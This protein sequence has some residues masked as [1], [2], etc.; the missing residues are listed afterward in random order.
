MPVPHHR[1]GQ[2]TIAKVRDSDELRQMLVDP[3]LESETI[4][5]K[6]NWVTNEP[7]D[8]TESGTLRTLIEA[9]DSRIVITESHN[10]A[11]SMNLLENGMNFT[12]GSREV[13]WRWLLKGDGWNWLIEMSE[14][15][16]PASNSVPRTL[17]RLTYRVAMSAEMGVD[18]PSA[19][20]HFG[21]R[22]K[23]QFAHLG[24]VK[25]TVR[26][27]G[28][29]QEIFHDDPA[30]EVDM[31]EAMRAY[32]EVGFE[33][34]MRPDHAP[35]MIGDQ[36]FEGH[37]G[38]YTLGKMLALGYMKGLAQSIEAEHKRT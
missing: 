22:K 13:N 25:G 30:G 12:V 3:W 29:F 33:G 27:P 38:Y 21:R 35:K 28:G 8:F 7:A 17:L 18:V 6:P 36:A 20:R 31:I 2:T 4:I 5:I 37:E 1:F 24:N 26:E 10:I 9:L 19:I 34:P 23:I 11:R 14:G 16:L 15:I 32:Y